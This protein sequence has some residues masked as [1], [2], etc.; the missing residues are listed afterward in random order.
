[1]GRIGISFESRA[2]RVVALKRSARVA[3]RRP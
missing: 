1:M 2:L 3:L